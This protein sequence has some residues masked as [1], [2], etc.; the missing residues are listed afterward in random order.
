MRSKIITYEGG[1]LQPVE[2]YLLL[3]RALKEL[4]KNNSQMILI[5]LGGKISGSA[6]KIVRK[7][8]L[9]NNVLVTGPLPL[10]KIPLYLS[11]SDA[12]VLPLQNNFVDASRWP[13]RLLEY[14]ASGR[15]V[16][17]SA[18]GESAKIIGDEGCGLLAKP[19]DHRDFTE[20][21]RYLLDNDQMAE[22][23]GKKGRIAVERKYNWIQ[24]CKSYENMYF[25]LNARTNLRD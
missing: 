16:V 1:S 18:V 19:S 25:N 17:A 22:E 4:L 8:Q 12:L 10:G 13:N 14:M 11:A 9:E 7:M 15:A 6:G 2:H 24:I 21:L 3:V 20:K 5:L 23:L